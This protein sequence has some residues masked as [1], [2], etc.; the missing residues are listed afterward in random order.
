MSFYRQN[1]VLEAVKTVLDGT[2][3]S[4]GKPVPATIGEGDLDTGITI[5]P[6]DSP[7]QQFHVL[8]GPTAAVVTVQITIAGRDATEARLIGDHARERLA[9]LNDDGTRKH[10]IGLKL[11][12][13]IKPSQGHSMS[14]TGIGVWVERFEIIFGR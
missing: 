4:G 2:I 9:G 10:P 13:P 7:R 12:T 6:V 5:N 14:T 3:T 11:V 8:G 1:H